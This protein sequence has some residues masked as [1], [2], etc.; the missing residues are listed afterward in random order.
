MVSCKSSF[1]NIV[2][3]DVFASIHV[4]L[5]FPRVS[6]KPPPLV[7]IDKNTSV[8]RSERKERKNSHASIICHRRLNATSP[9]VTAAQIQSHHYYVGFENRK[10]HN[11]PATLVEEEHGTDSAGDESQGRG[12]AADT[13]VRN[14]GGSLRL[15]SR[16]AG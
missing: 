6:C 10:Y 2:K 9:W 8:E 12:Q 15:V 14:L 11:S 1:V 16:G 13:A 5:A 4:K 7:S 3:T